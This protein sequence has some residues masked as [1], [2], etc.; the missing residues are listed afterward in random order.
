MTYEL[1]DVIEQ[2]KKYPDTFKIPS[3]T[4]RKGVKVGEWAK[5]IFIAPDGQGERMW[6]KVTS[7]KGGKYVGTLDNSPVFIDAA[8]GDEIN[9]S[10][11]HVASIMGDEEQQ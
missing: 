9:F 6:V 2:S 7:R 5:L 8:H 3:H 10:P 1:Q 11:K 4:R